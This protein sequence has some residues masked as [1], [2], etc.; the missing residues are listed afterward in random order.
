MMISQDEDRVQGDVST[1]SPDTVTLKKQFGAIFESLQ[2]G[3]V[4]HDSLGKVIQHNEA[5]F[6]ILGVTREQL[7]GNSPFDPR[8]RAVD[9][10]NRDVKGEEHPAMVALRTGQSQIDHLIG[11]H[12]PDNSLRWLN[13]TAIPIFHEGEKTPYQVLITFRDI[14]EQKLSQAKIL[15]LR[16]ESEER[17]KFLSTVL[18]NISAL[19]SYWDSDLKNVFSNRVCAEYFGK[20]PGEI[21]GKYI[22][23][24]FGEELYRKNERYLFEV[25]KGKT[26]TFE[27]VIQTAQGSTIDVLANYIPDIVDGKVVGFYAVI[28]DITRLKE[29]ERARWEIE[30]KLVLGAKMSALGEMASGIAH[31]INNPLAIINAKAANIRLSLK[32]GRMSHEQLGLELQKIEVT[33][34]RITKI[35]SGLRVFARD[36]ES[37][38]F[39]RE[40]IH[41]IVT[42]TLNFCGEK[43][44]VLNIELKLDLQEDVFCLCRATQISQIVM[45]LLSNSIDSISDR[46]EKWIQITSKIIGDRVDIRVTDSGPPIPRNI[47]ERMMEPFF[48]T[49]DYGKGTGLGLS[50]SKSLAEDNRG[51]LFFDSSGDHPCFVLQI[52]N[53]IE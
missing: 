37:D 39:E 5:A 32:E 30:A 38:P 12:R 11:V 35:I 36:A 6:R 52:P 44:K 10:N 47:S 18:N 25:L 48:T 9:E 22:R 31:E 45:N 15:E 43:M 53:C 46:K 29:L 17:E 41:A 33:V 4:V 1:T 19:I 7:L 42:D 49:K 40:S 26:Q 27:R 24:F 14:T 13:C 20:T 34:E 50:I 21:Q 16:R 8:W 2:D 3:I 51:I 23:D 28:T